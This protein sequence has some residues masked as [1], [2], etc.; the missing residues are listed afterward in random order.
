MGRKY[1][2]FGAQTHTLSSFVCRPKYTCKMWLIAVTPAQH[3]INCSQ[4]TQCMYSMCARALI[5]TGRVAHEVGTHRHR[6]RRRGPSDLSHT[7]H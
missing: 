6:G 5:D 4:N 1:Q 2:F 3:T 7:L